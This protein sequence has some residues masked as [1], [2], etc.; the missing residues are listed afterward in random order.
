MLLGKE[1]E[2]KNSLEKLA[3]KKTKIQEMKKEI[4]SLNGEIKKHK[5]EYAD[6]QTKKQKI[7]KNTKTELEGE[8][9]EL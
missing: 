9:E 6:L 8:I 2:L 1:V 5:A 3:E 4:K 7:L